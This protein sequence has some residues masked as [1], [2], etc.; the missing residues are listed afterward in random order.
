MKIF[1]TVCAKLHI[2]WVYTTFEFKL[3]SIAGMYIYMD[4]NL[5]WEIAH[6]TFA[7]FAAIQNTQ[8]VC[9]GFSGSTE[10]FMKKRVYQAVL[11]LGQKGQK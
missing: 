4:Y 9:F 7:G 11:G 2:V 8:S 10:G 1:Y 6:E 3:I 5:F